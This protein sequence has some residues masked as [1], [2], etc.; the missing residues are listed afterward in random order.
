MNLKEKLEQIIQKIPDINV[1]AVALKITVKTGDDAEDYESM[2]SE[3]LEE[4]LEDLE[5][6]LSTL[7]DNEP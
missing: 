3:E 5:D 1:K 6:Q 2:T 7:Q 4:L